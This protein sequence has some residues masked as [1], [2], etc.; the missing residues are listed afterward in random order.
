MIN[1]SGVPNLHLKEIRKVIIKY[2]NSKE[3]QK[4]I[5]NKLNSI[6]KKIQDLINNLISKKDLLF[7]LENKMLS[8]EFN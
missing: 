5:V 6:D 8:K 3:E 4:I 1:S 2:P 7:V